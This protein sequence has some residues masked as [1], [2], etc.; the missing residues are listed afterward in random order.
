VSLSEV[1]LIGLLSICNFTLRLVLPQGFEWRDS[2]HA[3]LRAPRVAAF[4]DELSRIPTHK[5][6]KSPQGAD[7]TL[8]GKAVNLQLIR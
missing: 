6:A 7:Q 1:S 5:V 4:L 3:P 8:R 2:R